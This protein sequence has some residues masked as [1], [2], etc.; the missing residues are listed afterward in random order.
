M[1]AQTPIAFE[2]D[3]GARPLPDHDELVRAVLAC[4]PRA[5]GGEP[6]RL[7]VFNEDGE[8]YWRIVTREAAFGAALESLAR[9]GFSDELAV[10]KSP[11]G[12][13]DALLLRA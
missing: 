10:H 11:V 1:Q 6:R 9:R 8:I 3:A 13:Y 5:A 2:F 7:G 4:A 12:G